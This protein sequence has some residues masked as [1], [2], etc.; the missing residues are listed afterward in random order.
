[1]L[2]EIFADL[3]LTQHA[4]ERLLTN[5]G[6]LSEAAFYLCGLLSSR[7]RGAGR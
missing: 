6:V 4:T 1:L 3:G 7:I 5:M 2:I